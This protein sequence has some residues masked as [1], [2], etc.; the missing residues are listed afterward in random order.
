MIIQ[1]LF[2]PHPTLLALEGS[3]IFFM[4]AWV[5]RLNS[6]VSLP[7]FFHLVAFF[8][9]DGKHHQTRQQC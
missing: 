5:A 7:S 4:F 3:S 6:Q 1:S 2:C 8:S 9:A